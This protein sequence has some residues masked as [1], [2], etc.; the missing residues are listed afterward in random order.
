MRPFLKTHPIKPLVSQSHSVNILFRF[1]CTKTYLAHLFGLLLAVHP[2]LQDGSTML[3]RSQSGSTF[4]SLWPAQSWHS[5]GTYRE[6]KEE[7]K[8]KKNKWTQVLLTPKLYCLCWKWLRD[9]LEATWG[10]QLGLRILRYHLFPGVSYS[11]HYLTTPQSTPSPSACPR[12]ASGSNGKQPV[13][14]HLWHTPNSAQCLRSPGNVGHWREEPHCSEFQGRCLL[15]T[16][17]RCTSS[18]F[19]ACVKDH[20]REGCSEEIEATFKTQPRGV[21]SLVLLPRSSGTE[22]ETWEFQQRSQTCLQVF[23]PSALTCLRTDADFMVCCNSLP[24][25]TQ[26]SPDSQ[27][28]PYK[29]QTCLSNI[30]SLRWLHWLSLTCLLDYFLQIMHIWKRV[31]HIFIIYPDET[32]LTAKYILYLKPPHKTNETLAYCPWKLT[33]QQKKSSQRGIFPIIYPNN[34]Q[35]WNKAVG[36]RNLVTLICPKI[37]FFTLRSYSWQ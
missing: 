8:E 17:R 9:V 14:H 27:K 31:K 15:W 28:S 13:G 3:A 1:H 18:L 12:S 22:Q 24:W 19:I 7:G 37:H 11:H 36:G 34:C 4:D 30:K 10:G 32:N 20:G 33:K 25:S 2:H 6:R 5:I 23:L 29:L 26:C 35:F 21:E 16:L